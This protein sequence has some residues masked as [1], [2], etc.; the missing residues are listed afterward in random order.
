MSK[1]I[2]M[3]REGIDKVKNELKQLLDVQQPQLSKKMSHA[4]DYG[5]LSEN[6]EY[7]AIKEEMENL[8]RRIAR[9]QGILSRAQIFDPVGI[10]PNEITLLSTVEL[11]DLK[12]NRKIT[13]TLVSPEEVNIDQNRISVE[14]PVGKGLIGK[15]AGE[16]VSIE[17]PV[18][19]IEYE[20]LSV[21]RE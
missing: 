20:I 1:F 6:A 2:Y 5:D 11:K 14:S 12:K 16:T 13:Y 10:D 18:G 8:Q 7:D 21:K 9:L 3:S 19:I 15:K 4:R 17:V